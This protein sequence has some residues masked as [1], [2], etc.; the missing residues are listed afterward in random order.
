MATPPSPLVRR[1]ETT[2]P[3]W[4]MNLNINDGTRAAADKRHQTHRQCLD[5]DESLNGVD[6]GS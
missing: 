1:P 3:T 6:A 5:V 2:S 4:G